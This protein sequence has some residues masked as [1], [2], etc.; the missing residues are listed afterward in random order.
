MTTN[1]TA[2]R[3][4]L[5]QFKT[6]SLWEKA[7]KTYALE[8]LEATKENG[9]ISYPLDLKQFL[10]GAD[11]WK[12]YSWGG[13]ALIYNH[14]LA[15]RFCTPFELKRKKDGMLPPNSEEQW[16]DVQTRALHQAFSLLAKTATPN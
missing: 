8:L 7:V 4:T 13:C 1:I 12:H 6:K 10:N 2:T 14:H 11:N 9:D 15:E 3:A 16:L 5:E